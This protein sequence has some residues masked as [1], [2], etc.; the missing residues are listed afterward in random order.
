MIPAAGRSA[1]SIAVEAIRGRGGG[2]KIVYE[3]LR[4]DEHVKFAGLYCTLYTDGGV[5]RSGATIRVSSSV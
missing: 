4:P 1:H 2:G 3:N 5:L